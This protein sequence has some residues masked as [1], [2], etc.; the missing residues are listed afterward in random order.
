MK[1]L[2]ERNQERPLT[3]KQRRFSEEYCV[4]FNGTRAALRA[5][6]SPN[7][8]DVAATRL[9]KNANVLRIIEE[10]MEAM[11]MSAAEAQTRLTSIGRGTMEGIVNLTASKCSEG[12]AWP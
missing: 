10:R 11:S 12:R 8:A 6:Y 7:G 1:S 3:A 2:K 9:L 4:D 5:N